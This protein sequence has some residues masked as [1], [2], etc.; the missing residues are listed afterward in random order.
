MLECI[1]GRGREDA[2]SLPAVERF[3]APPGLPGQALS[4]LTTG[5]EWGVTGQDHT[6]LAILRLLQQQQHGVRTR[7]HCHAMNMGAKRRYGEKQRWSVV[8]A[9]RG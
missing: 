8:L 1:Y 9:G 4:A 2:Q 3:A 6:A 7:A 5:Q